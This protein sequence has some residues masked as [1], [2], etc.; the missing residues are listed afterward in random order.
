MMFK[1]GAAHKSMDLS[2]FC[3]EKACYGQSQAIANL[4]NTTY[5]GEVGWT[6]EAHIVQ[7]DRTNRQQIEAILSKPDTHFF[8]VNH[9]QTLAAC[10]YVAKEKEHAYIGFFSVHPSLQG[11]GLGKYV[12][13]QAEIFAL[14]NMEVHKFVMFVISQR[15]ELIAFYERRGYLRTGRIEAYPLHLGMGIPKVSGLTIEY[16]EKI[17]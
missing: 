2:Q 6:T 10:I 13:E 4:V 15:P 16:L 14:E 9:L 1:P 11:K 8:V 17:T 5:R 3:L 12:L 7:S